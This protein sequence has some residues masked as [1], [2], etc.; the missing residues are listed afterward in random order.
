MDTNLKA[1]D[2]LIDLQEVMAI[3]S[4][5]R[6]QIYNLMKHQDFPL[7]L[8]LSS[9]KA[10]RCSRWSLNEIH[11]WIEQKKSNRAVA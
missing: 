1:A 3:T 11:L 4:V 2:K 7:S 9:G 6:S 10:N 8:S 5:S